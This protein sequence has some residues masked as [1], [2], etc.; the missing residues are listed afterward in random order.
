VARP[1]K[2]TIDYFPHFVG[3]GKTLTILESRFGNDGYAFWFKLLEIL[4]GTDGHVYAYIN[5]VDVEFLLAKTRVSRDTADAILNLLAELGAIDPD[6]WAEGIIWSDNFVQ[7][8]SE[9]YAR[10]K[11]SVPQKPRVSGVSADINSAEEGFCSENSDRNPQSKVKYTKVNNKDISSNDD[12]SP[13][14]SS[15]TAEDIPDPI[16]EVWGHYQAQFSDVWKRS[17][18]FTQTRKSAIK[19]RLKSYSVEELC[20]AVTNIRASPWHVGQNPNAKVYATPEFI[21][22]KDEKVEEWLNYDPEER[23]KSGGRAT[24]RQRDPSQVDWDA[25]AAK[26]ADGFC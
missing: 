4:G 25:E 19:A 7:N 8:I 16:A 9:V 3:G 15:E 11:V 23:G 26:W 10:R 20:R 21:F 1:T 24:V 2:R 6:L 22:R 13:S 17:L 12:D 14:L 5:P 18:K